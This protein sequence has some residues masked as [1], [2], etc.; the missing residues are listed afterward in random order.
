MPKKSQTNETEQTV[1]QSVDNVVEQA[2]LEQTFDTL[3]ATM[4]E[5]IGEAYNTVRTVKSNLKML[6]RYHRRELKNSRK[7]R[8]SHNANKGQKKPSGFNKPGP[9]PD[10][11]VKLLNIEEGVELPRTK[12]TKLIYG[13]IKEHNLQV[14]EDKRTINP[15][16]ALRTLFGL[17]K[18]EQ[19]SFYN[20]QTHIKKLYP[21]KV[22]PV[23]EPEEA[24]AVVEVE[25]EDEA[26]AE[27]EAE[28][29]VK[30]SKK[31]K[32]NKSNKKHKS[33]NAHA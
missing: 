30:K 22:V 24:E 21:S 14:P 4:L 25:V 11:I 13:Y 33:S 3:Y 16:K 31:S 32:G 7:Y 26:E 5:Q 28:T 2:E 8:K 17:D 6:E 27:V 20:I 19:I 15:D 10:T 1:E 23:T 18:G 9:V 29:P 12:V